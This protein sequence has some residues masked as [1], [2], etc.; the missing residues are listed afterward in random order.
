[1]LSIFKGDGGQA[2]NFSSFLSE[3]LTYFV[4][5]DE[6]A[7]SVFICTGSKAEDSFGEWWEAEAVQMVQ[8]FAI[9]L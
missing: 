7:A 8:V 1:M 4:I 2:D 9:R 6:I 5:G 3:V